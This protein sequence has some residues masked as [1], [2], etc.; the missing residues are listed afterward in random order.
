MNVYAIL[1]TCSV[2]LCRDLSSLEIHR[3]PA[4][5]ATITAQTTVIE[6]IGGFERSQSIELMCLDSQE[7]DLCSPRKAHFLNS[8][9]D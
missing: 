5:G 8:L 1:R 9:F 6:A 2:L 7:A 4:G 3:H